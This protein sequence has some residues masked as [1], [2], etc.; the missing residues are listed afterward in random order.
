M[1]EAV[2]G[3]GELLGWDID[4]DGSLVPL[5][6]ADLGGYIK[7]DGKEVFRRAVR[8]M[9]DSAEKSMKHA[10]VTADDIELVV[11]HQANI[12]IIEAACSRLGIPMER[13]ATHDRPHRQHVVGVDPARAGR[14]P[15]RTA[16]S[17]TATSCC[18]S[19]SA[20]A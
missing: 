17:P 9:V 14:G 13:A 20:P 12:R 2:D 5:L 4:A 1:L 11:P 10:G 8:I 18:W 16:A 7:M 19:A 15:R 3:P 6:Y